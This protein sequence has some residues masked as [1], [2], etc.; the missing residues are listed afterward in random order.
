METELP[1]TWK[2]QEPS[3]FE[4]GE[5]R[6]EWDGLMFLVVGSRRV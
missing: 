1:S 3:E 2:E 6:R 5:R 4:V